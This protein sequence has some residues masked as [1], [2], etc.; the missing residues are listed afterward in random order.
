MYRINY[1]IHISKRKEKKW[2]LTIGEEPVDKVV[3]ELDTF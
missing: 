2:N 3:V 1:N